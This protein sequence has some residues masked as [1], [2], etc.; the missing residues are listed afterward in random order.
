MGRSMSSQ[1]PNTKVNL[2]LFILP[3]LICTPPCSYA[4]THLI[5]THPSSFSHTHLIFTPPSSFSHTHL[6]FTHPSSYSPTHLIFTHPSSY[7]HTHLIFTHPSSCSHTHLI[8]THPSSYSH[9]HP[10]IHTPVLT[11][12]CRSAQPPMAPLPSHPVNSLLV[13]SSNPRFCSFA[14]CLQN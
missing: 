2:S 14:S 8:F 6:I 12:I 13:V 1:D 3:S 11:C 7:S 9:P 10:H 4:H 5:F